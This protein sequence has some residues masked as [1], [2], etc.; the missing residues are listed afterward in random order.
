MRLL[1]YK[2]GASKKM[3]LQCLARRTSCD[4]K[5]LNC[6]AFLSADDQA[7]LLP[8]STVALDRNFGQNTDWNVSIDLNFWTQGS[9]VRTFISG[10]LKANCDIG[11]QPEA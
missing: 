5:P 7:V 4:V 9:S 6:T 2:H 10:I 3:A 8:A 1:S 11:L